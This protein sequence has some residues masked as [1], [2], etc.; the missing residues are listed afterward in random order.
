MGITTKLFSKEINKT[1]E[2]KIAIEK[3]IMEKHIK[4][5]EARMVEVSEERAQER[6]QELFE[7]WRENLEK[8]EKTAKAKEEAEA[9]S[10]LFDP[11][12]LIESLGY[13]ERIMSISYD[14]LR[15]MAERNPIIAAVIT[16]RIHQICSFARPPRSRYE[17]G[18]EIVMRDSEDKPSKDDKLKMKEL[19]KMIESTG[20]PEIIEEESRDSFE[21]FLAKTVR[22][23]LTFD[24]LCFEICDG[25]GGFP[26][27]FYA[28][29][30]S[31]IR[32]AST[33][34]L[35]RRVAGYS[36]EQVH[37]MWLRQMEQVKDLVY[38]K[39]RQPE[40]EEVRYVQVINGRVMNTYSEK[41]I[42]FGVRNPRTNIRQ[43]NY[44]VS[45]LEILVSTVTS[46]LYAEE[47]N[48]RIFS[49]G[50]A[51][52]GIIHFEQAGIPIPQQELAS[53]RRQWHAQ[54]AGVWN[55]WKTPI[56]ATPGK[57]IYTNLQQTNRQMEFSHWIEYLIKLICACY[58]I[59]PSEINF[60]LRGSPGQAPLFE[61]RQEA[62]LKISRDRGLRPL[63]R[64]LESEINKNIVYRINPRFELQFIGLDAKSESE[65]QD[66]KIKEL[67]AFKVI[68]EIR[69][70]YDL[71]PIGD[72]KGGDLIMEPT[73]IN[74][75]QQKAMAAAQAGMMM[76]GPGAPGG[77]A[78]EEIPSEKE[79]DFGTEEEEATEKWP[80]ME[81][82]EKTPGT[83][84]LDRILE[85]LKRQRAK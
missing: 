33:P 83:K 34:S 43:N 54:V 52:K 51:A 23:S 77:P 67:K 60:D 85:E 40:A 30:S 46:H 57:M 38:E 24:Q 48:K 63:L 42:G 68:D 44:G 27:A 62:K 55:S 18:F 4:E 45:E 56:I 73:Y 47:Y 66:L 64:F 74:Y 81:L 15:L 11:F 35:L 3:T 31:T 12:Q 65:L 72:E 2:E 49:T 70:E 21:A 58:L 7:Q 53:F 28:I 6:A 26:V 82:P 37:Q 50:S 41:E 79:F 1:I 16:T 22:D 17:T 5:T 76:G 36:K 78:A 25:R 69:A 13:K 8:A 71:K 75:R 80:E 20:L 39:E 59:D 9:K 29:D 32:Y 84:E 61:G 14:T 19:T 10:Y